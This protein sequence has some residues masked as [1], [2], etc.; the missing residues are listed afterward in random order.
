MLPK[1]EQTARGC[2]YCGLFLVFASPL[3]ALNVTH[4]SIP[5]TAL[6]ST[7]W[8]LPAAHRLRNPAWPAPEG[9]G[10]SS[11]T[12]HGKQLWRSHRFQGS[13]HQASKEARAQWDFSRCTSCRPRSSKEGSNPTPEGHGDWAKTHSQLQQPSGWLQLPWE[14]APCEQQSDPKTGSS[15]RGLEGQEQKAP[16]ALGLA[17]SRF[18]EGIKCNCHLLRFWAFGFGFLF[19]FF[20]FSFNLWSRILV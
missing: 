13:A 1:Q 2:F 17:V 6:F 20:F 14:P 10:L 8:L 9:L 3:C 7:R 16:T 11:H 18:R 4:T 19:W 5:Q 15:P 12:L